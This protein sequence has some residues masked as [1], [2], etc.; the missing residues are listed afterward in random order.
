MSNQQGKSKGVVDIVFLIDIT[1]SMGICIDA[2]KSNLQTFVT[3]LTSDDGGPNSPGPIVKDFRIKIVGYRDVNADGADWFVD[4]P[5]TT[6][7]SVASQQIAGLVADGGGEIPESLLDALHR[8][9]TMPAT[10]SGASA[11]PGQWRHRRDALRV[12][13]V[14]TDAPFH[15]VMGYPGGR[16][17]GVADVANAAM[18]NKIMIECFAPD[19]DCYAEIETIDKCNVHRI[20]FDSSD[21]R[22]P[23][24]ALA[25]YTSDKANFAKVMA[26]LG[27]SISKSAEV[28]IL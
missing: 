10:E 28:A 18:A 11:D 21:R 2:V 4:H 13:V 24:K 1:G 8:V 23:Q 15:P 26:S 3:S 9:C 12:V 14:F 22:G 16:G 5:F 7:V 6:E 17:G 19:L 20:E 27:K 25:A